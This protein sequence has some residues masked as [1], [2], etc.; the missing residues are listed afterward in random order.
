MRLLLLSTPAPGL[1]LRLVKLFDRLRVT[2]ESVFIVPP[3]LGSGHT[4]RKFFPDD[5][6]EKFFFKLLEMWNF[7][8]ELFRRNLCGTCE[9]LIF[10]FFLLGRGGGGG[11]LIMRKIFKRLSY[12]KMGV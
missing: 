10:F 1:E 6:E 3:T 2:L 11:T 7:E 5:S 9:S 8:K 4:R 12:K